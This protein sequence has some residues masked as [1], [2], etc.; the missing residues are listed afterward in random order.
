MPDKKNT[1]ITKL[2]YIH[3]INYDVIFKFYNSKKYE[4]YGKYVL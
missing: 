4:V 2:L 1:P 3:F